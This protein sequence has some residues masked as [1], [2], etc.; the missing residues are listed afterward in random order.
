MS[1]NCPFQEFFVIP[2][3]SKKANE[4]SWRLSFPTQE[5]K[6]THSKLCVKPTIKLLKVSI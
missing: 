5:N 3:R 1:S 6:I 4:R 2:K